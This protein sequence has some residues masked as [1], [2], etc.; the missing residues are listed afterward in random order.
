MN[1]FETI[2]LIFFFVIAYALGLFITF[3]ALSFTK[4][5]QPALFYLYPLH[6]LITF[7]VALIRKEVKSLWNGKLVSIFLF[8]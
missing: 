7:L 2:F 3:I 6:L 1:I 8:L 5:A 4:T